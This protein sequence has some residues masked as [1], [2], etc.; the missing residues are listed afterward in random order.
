MI[1]GFTEPAGSRAGLGALLL[2]VHDKRS[3][4][5]Y[6]G[7]VGTGFTEQT[8]KELRSRLHPLDRKSPPFVNP[9]RAEKREAFTG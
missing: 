2:G 7:K 9:P 4:L 5:V 8:L 6:A 1:G 3:N